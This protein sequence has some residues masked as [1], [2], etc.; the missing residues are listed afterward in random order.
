[1]KSNGNPLRVLVI[2]L[3]AAL[4]LVACGGSETTVEPTR[5]TPS[6]S[7]PTMTLFP[8]SLSSQPAAELVQPLHTPRDP[9]VTSTTLSPVQT[10]ATPTLVSTA[11]PSA[12]SAEPSLAEHVVLPGETLLGLAFEN[13]ISMASIQLANGMGSSVDLIAGQTLAIPRSIQWQGEDYYWIVHV[14]QAEETLVGLSSAYGLMVEDILR[15]NAVADPDL[16]HVGRQLIIPLSQL[17]T[18]NVPQPTPP[19]PPIAAANEQTGQSAPDATTEPNQTATE[20]PPPTAIPPPSLPAG[21]ADWPAYLLT[22]VN[23]ARAA[24]GLNSLVLIPELSNAA[25]A[26]AQDCAQ[27]GWGSHV[28]SDGAVL[29][30]RLERAGYFGRNSGEN[31]V[32]ALNAE[33]AFEWWF[34][35]VPPNDPHRRNILSP[36][37]TEIGIGIAKTDWG[38]IY[39]T[40]FG[41]R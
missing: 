39:V 36:Y 21:P 17:V 23:Q 2:P 26:H 14:V 5:Q 18:E 30:T 13:S 4:W 41:R 12:E 24:H 25:Q 8:G 37:Y 32:Q 16:I 34:G 20:V 33:R 10:L 35:E 9:S 29:K 38:Y 6:K 28:G 22:R 27:R 40:D 15:V 11:S 3:F 19:P 7:H 1:M 31:W